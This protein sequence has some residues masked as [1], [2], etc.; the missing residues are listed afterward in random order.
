MRLL[1]L[2]ILEVVPFLTS[3]VV[4]VAPPV[5]G[6]GPVVHVACHGHLLP[7]ELHRPHDGWCRRRS[8]KCTNKRGTPRKARVDLTWRSSTLDFWDKNNLNNKKTPRE[9]HNIKTRPFVLG[10]VCGGDT[11]KPPAPLRKVQEQ[12]WKI[13]TQLSGH[14]TPSKQVCSFLI[15]WFKSTNQVLIIK[16]QVL[17][18]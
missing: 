10:A 4:T 12:E 15:A 13:S 3:V 14:Y 6:M 8:L 9:T 2:V 5:G 11:I 17:S 16:N 1:S 18:Q 7:V